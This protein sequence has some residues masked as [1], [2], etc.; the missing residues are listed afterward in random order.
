QQLDLPG[1]NV[2]AI[3]GPIGVDQQA[4]TVTKPSEETGAGI[5][6]IGI[7]PLISR[8]ERSENDCVLPR[9]S[10]PLKGYPF[11]IWGPR[12]CES[13]ERIRRDF[14]GKINS[15]SSPE[16]RHGLNLWQILPVDK[17]CASHR[18]RK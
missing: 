16:N 12:G 11:A 4:L 3:E 7:H 9:G 10:R 18:D 6:E 1:L 17:R 2:K 8:F 13:L 14:L 5:R 15:P